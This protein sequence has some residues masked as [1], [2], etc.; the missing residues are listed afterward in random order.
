MTYKV[1][2]KQAVNRI[3]D[4]RFLTEIDKYLTSETVK[5][6]WRYLLVIGITDNSFT[7][8]IGRKLITQIP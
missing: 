1:S 5:I 6:S 7:D 2:I 3:D 8:S 4:D